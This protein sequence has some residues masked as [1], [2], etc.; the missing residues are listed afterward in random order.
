M[1]EVR[2]L[3]RPGE[4]QDVA[5]TLRR[6]EVLGLT[7]LLGA[8]R[9]ELALTLFGMTRPDAGEIRLEGG[10]SRCASNQDAI[11]AGIA[12]VSEDR[13]NLGLNMRQSVGDNL[14]LA[15]AEPLS[16]R[17]GWI[18]PAPARAGSANGSSA[19][20]SR[21]P[22]STTRCSSSPGGN[23]QRVVLGKWLATDPRC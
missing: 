3:T 8:G 23:Q 9:T 22:A 4:Y 21:S 20:T 14:V 5:F 15:V 13:L 16:N 12:Y 17:S 2:G 7:G 18:A 6:G 1:L 10:R 11:A 19:C